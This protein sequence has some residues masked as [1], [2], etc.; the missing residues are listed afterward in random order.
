[1]DQGCV[2]ESTILQLLDGTLTPTQRPAVEAHLAT[3]VA[4]ADLVTWAAADLL[5]GQRPIAQGLRLASDPLA[6]GTR[7]GRYQILERVGRGGMGV[8]YAAYHPD[9]DRKIALKVVHETGADTAD[10]QA[11]LLREAKAIARLQH[12]NVVAVYDA[13]TVANHV[14]VAMEFVDGLTIDRWLAAAPRSWREVLKVFVA[15]GRGLAAAHEAGLVHRDFKPQN[16]MIAR[17]GAVRVMDFGLARMTAGEPAAPAPAAA[18]PPNGSGAAA[19]VTHAGTIV[20]TPAYMAPE[21]FRGELADARSDQF[22]FCVALYEALFHER[23]FPGKQLLSLSMTV[24]EG[25]LRLPPPA[26]LHEVP[27]WIRKPLFRGLRPDPRQRH[28]SMTELIAVLERDPAAKRRRLLGVG[29]IAAAVLASAAFT[30][31]AT[32]QR[33][34]AAE[35]EIAR[36]LDDATQASADARAKVGEATGLRAGAFDAFDRSDRPGGELLW[37][38]ARGLLPV[39]D[40]AYD[41][42]ERSLEAALTLDGS[43]AQ[44]PG[45]L[46]DLRQ[47]HFLFAEAFRL[48]SKAGVLEE[49]LATVDADGSRRKALAAP[50]SLAVRTSPRA[51][52]ILLERYELDPV[53]GRRRP[54]VVGSLPAGGAD[55]TLPAG[56]YRLSIDGGGLARVVYPFEVAR[57]ERK[58][59]DLALPAAAA[60]PKDLVYVPPGTFWYGDADEQLR[61]QFLD[62]VPVHQRTTGA[63]LIARHETT[64][65]DWIAFLD[66]LPAA[67][68]SRR[69]PTIAGTMRGALALRSTGAGWRLMIQPSSRRYEA[70]T[71]ERITYEG[72]TRRASQNW[73]RFPIG[74]VSPDD[75]R[76][77]F[78]WLSDTGRVPGA[79]FCTDLEWERAARGADDRLFPHGDD[80]GPDDANFDLTYDRTDG[81]Y[82]P[83]EVGAHPE[84]RSPFE[85]DDLAGNIM[86]MVASSE[87][88][89]AL[90]LRGGSYY[91]TSATARSTNR[92]P[93]PRSSGSFRDVAI[94]LRVCADARR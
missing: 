13:G 94:G 1:M 62:T 57:G 39:I 79:R 42:A 65:Q 5:S 66:D 44:H 12:P 72:R 15:A 48:S 46:A 19:T 24:T 34:A 31:Q 29:V 25:D 8:V 36:H 43:R 90:L 61:K 77:Y 3:C 7:V 10:R 83:D 14:Y 20:G 18:P 40:M 52:R 63:Y 64:Y 80:L 4:C 81:A 26:K 71:H 11:R 87:S 51:A 78:A 59:I 93:V 2:P 76:R 69:A 84:S 74:G 33:R 68:R 9:L 89:D 60:I 28:P 6:P 37:R 53:T 92:E 38:K 82:G 73:L 86:E 91:F 50:G 21:Q 47:E 55:T 70:G 30:W 49:R 75:A 35:R 17:D 32:S 45:A 85:V 54:G 41:R 23:P 67:E 56:S 22:S 58:S 27:V 16:V 88:R